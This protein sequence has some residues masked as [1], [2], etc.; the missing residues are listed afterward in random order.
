MQRWLESF[1]TISRHHTNAFSHM[2]IIIQR[3]CYYTRC[4]LLFNY[5]IL[6]YWKGHI[7]WSSQ[8]IHK[9]LR[10][11]TY[12]NMILQIISGDFCY[13]WHEQFLLRN[14]Y[15]FS[16]IELP[17]QIHGLTLGNQWALHLDSIIAAHRRPRTSVIITINLDRELQQRLSVSHSTIINSVLAACRRW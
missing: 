2:T 5:P 14:C 12:R 9:L 11:N 3:H 10:F 15:T 4:L 8:G 13:K 17:H 16:L 1:I 6:L 7:L